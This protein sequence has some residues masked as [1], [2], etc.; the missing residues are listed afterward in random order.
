MNAR[1]KTLTLVGLVLTLVLGSLP[2]PVWDDEFADTAHLVCNE[3]IY[4]TLVAVTLGYVVFVERRPLAS[5]GFRRVGIV[6]GLCGV[7]M[8]IATVAGLAVLYFVV[9]PALGMSE[10]QQVDKLTGAPGWWLAMSV[11]RAGVSEEVLF[12]GYPIERLQEWSG[13]RAFAAGLPLIVFAFAHVGPWGWTH[14]L[15]AA[16][17][18]AMLTALYLWRRHPAFRDSIRETPLGA[19]PLH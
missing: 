9:L 12:R 8:A 2:Y 11:I 6:D 10:T 16:F 13:S 19:A 1:Q 18:G 5:I 3:I 4:W 7:G 17:G 14:L 15:I